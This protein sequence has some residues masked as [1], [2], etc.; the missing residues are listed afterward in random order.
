MSSKDKTASVAAINVAYHKMTVTASLLL[1][2]LH[3]IQLAMLFTTEHL[4]LESVHCYSSYVSSSSSLHTHVQV[5][6][7]KVNINQYVVH[8]YVN[9]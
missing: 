3:N 6:N 9:Y 2:K 5:I 7:I 4:T 1:N 8:Y